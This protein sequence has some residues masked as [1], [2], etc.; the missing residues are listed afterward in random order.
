MIANGETVST[1]R[2]MAALKKLNPKLRICSFEGSSRLAGLYVINVQ[3]E[4][5]DICGVDKVRVPAYAS[6]DDGGHVTKS[7][8]RR[9]FWIL[10]GNGYTTRRQI[11][12]VCPGFFDSRAC[13]ADRFTG[14]IM[15]DKIQNKL[16]KYISDNTH[17]D[18]LADG[19]LTKEQVLDVA[20]DIAA[21][22]SETT[23]I[24][25]EKDRWFLQKWQ[26]NGGGVN[27]RPT[28]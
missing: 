24:E 6:F 19:D 25:Q 15:G 4:W 14:G 17:G 11:Q 20:A 1:S 12:K 3:G 18:P 7:G 8:W 10:E 26:K 28:L 23:R 21:K 27:D 16:D 13:E 5:E 2:F 9:V 22:D